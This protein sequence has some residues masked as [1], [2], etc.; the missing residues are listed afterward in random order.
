MHVEDTPFL[1][2]GPPEGLLR[3]MEHLLQP[4]ERGTRDALCEEQGE[5]RA[6][7]GIFCRAAPDPGQLGV[8]YVALLNLRPARTDVRVHLSKSLRA[9]SWT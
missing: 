7:V 1:G 6:R 4:D 3:E 8:S 5:R 2:V 9:R